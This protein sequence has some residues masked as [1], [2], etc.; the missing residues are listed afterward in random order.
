MFTELRAPG[1]IGEG[2]MLLVFAVARL[3]ILSWR[4]SWF[5]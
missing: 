2:G 1:T 3:I 5:Y 4:G